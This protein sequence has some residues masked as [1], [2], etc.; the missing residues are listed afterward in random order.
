VLVFDSGPSSVR[1]Q[2]IDLRNQVRR[3]TGEVRR[4]G[5][6]GPGRL[7]HH[8]HGA[9]TYVQERQFADHD[10]AIAAILAAFAEA[11]PDLGARPPTAVGHRVTHG[12]ERFTEPVL[13]DDEVADEISNLTPLAP[14]RNPAAL[15]V[16]RAAR[17]ALPTLPHVAVFDT[18]FHQ[19]LPAAAHTYAVPRAW[20]EQFGVRRYGFHG[21]SYQ[22]VTRRAAAMLDRD[23]EELNLIALHLGDGASACAI[24]GGESVETSMG[25]TPLDGLVMG[26]RSGDVD[27]G[28]GGYLGRVAGLDPAA[29]E[30][31]LERDGGLLALAGSN[32][33]RDV[34]LAADRGDPAARLAMDVY[35]H[36][37]RKYVGAYYAVL[38]Q[39]DAV[40]FTAG[41]GE[42]VSRVRCQAL[43]GLDRLGIV[44]QPQ[45]NNAPGTGERF[46]SP[47][48][49]EV[50]VLVIPADE[51]A[52]IAGQVLDCV[53]RALAVR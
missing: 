9:V 13:V 3:A 20:R 25:L 34:C 36:R 24:A 27:P 8:P 30:A 43:T 28:L 4:I 53:S 44:V 22:Y 45:R 51:E 41:V 38:G 21:I 19:S 32:D 46:I 1:Y 49:A 6:P 17:A 23:P 26:T 47:A 7:S 42:H 50:P 10:E 12:G 33:L 40:V 11:G 2:L 18:A 48:G 39:V 31:A 37:I 16:L 52:E 14:L 5:G 29:V 35:C 15:A